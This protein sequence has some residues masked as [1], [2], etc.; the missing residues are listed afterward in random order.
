MKR[1]DQ[2]KFTPATPVQTVVYGWLA[3]PTASLGQL[4][5][6]AARLGVDVSPQA[7][8]RRFTMETAILLHQVLMA[9]LEQFSIVEEPRAP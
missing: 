6:M 5:Q 1:A 7:I 2:A 8:D 4:A 9:S 3:S